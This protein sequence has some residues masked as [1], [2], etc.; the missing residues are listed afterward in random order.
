MTDL[1]KFNV[2]EA[3]HDLDKTCYKLIEVIKSTAING[4][5]EGNTKE[6]ELSINMICAIGAIIRGN[7]I[8]IETMK[9][10]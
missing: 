5:L 1:Q 6:S 3:A 10:L 7:K 9:G 4:D 8:I 2:L